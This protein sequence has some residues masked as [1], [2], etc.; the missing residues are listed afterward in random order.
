[1]KGVIL[2]LLGLLAGLYLALS[3]FGIYDTTRPGWIEAGAY[4]FGAILPFLLIGLIAGFSESGVDALVRR[5]ARFLRETIPGLTN[6]LGDPPGSFEP[7]GQRGGDAIADRPKVELQ[8]AKNLGIANY[9]VTID[10]AFAARMDQFDQV[11][12]L[13][14]RI[15]LNA[16]KANVVI[17]LPA[18]N[19]GRPA[20]ALF[21][22]TIAGAEREGYW[23]SPEYWVQTRRGRAFHSLVAVRRLDPD[24]LTNPVK[25]LDFGHD[26]MIMLRALL[27]ERPDV[28]VEA[29]PAPEGG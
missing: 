28:F 11:R 14:F 24:F 26:L 12:M 1:M 16:T 19:A 15:E 23:F 7:A 27:E 8:S 20:A 3:L 25:R 10:P 29:D 21:P 13:R 4:L 18:A 17:H 2:A 9:A 6:L 5:N 22:L